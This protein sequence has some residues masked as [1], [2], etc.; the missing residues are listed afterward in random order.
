M[1]RIIF[2]R[3]GCDTVNCDIVPNRIF[4]VVNQSYTSVVKIKKVFVKLCNIGIKSV[5]HKAL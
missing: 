1:I 3:G 4:I 5:I 2:Y